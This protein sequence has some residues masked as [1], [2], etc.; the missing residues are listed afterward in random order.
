MGAMSVNPNSSQPMTSGS[1]Q[2]PANFSVPA[3]SALGVIDQARYSM[4]RSRVLGQAVDTLRN[5]PPGTAVVVTENASRWGNREF[6]G[7]HYEGM[8]V[9]EPMS[10]QQAIDQASL[11]KIGRPGDMEHSYVVYKSVMASQ[12]DTKGVSMMTFE[13]ANQLR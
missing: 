2:A 8:S 6:G 12:V 11:A 7:M 9:S 4:D 10:V 3:E 5:Q 13:Q 1:A